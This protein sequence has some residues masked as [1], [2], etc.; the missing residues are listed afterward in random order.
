MR[1]NYAYE[2]YFKPWKKHNYISSFNILLIFRYERYNLT[3]IKFPGL[4]FEFKIDSEGISS[5]FRI[6]VSDCDEETTCMTSLIV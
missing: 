3:R 4:S 6:P 1:T 5:D 2:G